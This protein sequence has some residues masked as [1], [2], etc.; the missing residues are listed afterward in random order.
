M[1]GCSLVNNVQLCYLIGGLFLLL[2]SPC[3]V[4]RPD[5]KKKKKGKCLSYLLVQLCKLRQKR[6]SKNNE[7]KN[8]LFSPSKTSLTGCFSEERVR[9]V[10]ANEHVRTWRRDWSTLGGGAIQQRR[11]VS[12]LDRAMH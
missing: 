12:K 7:K 2:G 11:S 1:G 10:K 3:E 9:R 5:L 6:S 4:R 8:H